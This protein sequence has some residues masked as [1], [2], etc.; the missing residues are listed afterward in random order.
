M[1]RFWAKVDKTEGCWTWNAT[2]R[3]RLP[4]RYGA[5][6][7]DGMMVSAHRVSWELH[8]GPIPVGLQVLHDCDN[9][10]CVR[11]GHLFL[12][13]HQLN[14]TDRDAKSRQNKGSAV[15]T[16]VLTEKDIPIIRRWLADGWNQR[17][18]ADTWGVC[19]GTIQAIAAGKT[20]RHV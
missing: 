5:I 20:W 17:R 16:A 4:C 11:P 12:G 13:T 9:P 14:M 18:V 6:K 10:L 7:I 8:H 3:G 15:N 2:T 19:K 1:D